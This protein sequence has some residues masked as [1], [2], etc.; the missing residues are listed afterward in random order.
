MKLVEVRSQDVRFPGHALEALER[1]E[2][3]GVTHYGKRRLV[4]L[5]GEE[6]ALV[7]PLLEILREG[8]PV[9]SELLMSTEDIALERALAEDR[10]SA[11]A[12]DELIERALAD[13]VR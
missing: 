9:P 1:N 11:P 2:I 6:F 3:V 8:R 13:S 5:S 10:E 12:E 4:C 7:E